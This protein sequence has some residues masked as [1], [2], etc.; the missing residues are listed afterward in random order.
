M[1]LPITYWEPS[2]PLRLASMLKTTSAAADPAVARRTSAAH[3]IADNVFVLN[4]LSSTREHRWRQRPE[5]RS[6]VEPLPS[7]KPADP[8]RSGRGNPVTVD[9]PA[10]VKWA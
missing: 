9:D 6:R 10:L 1:P 7:A 4:M 2:G 5:I 3:P 8:F